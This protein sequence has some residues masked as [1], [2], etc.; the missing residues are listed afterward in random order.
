MCKIVYLTVKRFDKPSKEFRCSLAK[1]LRN[2]GVEVVEKYN[3]DIFNIFRKHNTYGMAL[4]FDFYNDG[5]SGR[6]LTLRED[7]SYINR[8]FSYN[9]SNNLDYIQPRIRWREITFLKSSDKEWYKTFN[10]VSSETKVIFHLCTINNP[11][12]LEK[13]CLSFKNVIRT[14]ADEIIRCLRSEYDVE[15]YRKRVNIA[16]KKQIKIKR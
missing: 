13:Y 5:S 6:G 3:Q 4:S 8:E 10:K 15:N 14:F 7:S 2:R 12:D 16:R 9:L 11:L 1:E